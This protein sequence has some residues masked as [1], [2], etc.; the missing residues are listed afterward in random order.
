KPRICGEVVR[1]SPMIRQKQHLRTQRRRRRG[2]S[3]MLAM[4]Y[5]VLFGALALGFYAQVNTS[6]QIAK[7]EQQVIKALLAA[8]SGVNFM[9]Y[10]L[11]SV[12]IPANTQQP[13]VLQELYN[14][15]SAQIDPSANM[16]GR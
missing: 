4:L 9:R 5:L 3:S 13:Q 15:L 1:Q 12:Q 10:H 16:A 2:L 6:V 11:A 7:N 14:D 8:E